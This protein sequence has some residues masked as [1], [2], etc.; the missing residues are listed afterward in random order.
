MLLALHVHTNY[1]K[2]AESAVN[3]IKEFCIENNIGAIAICDH[4]EILGARELEKIASD[5]KVI[6]GE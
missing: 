6:I 1:S 3:D 5:F 2:C 4:N